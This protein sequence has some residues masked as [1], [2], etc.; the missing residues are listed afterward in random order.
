MITSELPTHLAYEQA[1]RL[2][3]LSPT[4][5]E[6][7]SM[8]GLKFTITYNKRSFPGVYEYRM[9]HDD[10]RGI[11]WRVFDTKEDAVE[12]CESFTLERN[13]KRRAHA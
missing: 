9:E 1:A 13:Q 2:R 5:W 10:G 12:A 11:H 8:D 3:Q 4:Q 6:Y 7:I